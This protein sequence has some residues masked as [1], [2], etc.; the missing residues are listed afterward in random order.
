MK[1]LIALALVAG[2]LATAGFGCGGET[3]KTGG[4]VTPPPGGGTGGKG[5][6]STGA[7]GTGAKP[8][9]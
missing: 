9:P 2:L 6:P 1:K 8:A 7:T 4:A 3:K 5:A